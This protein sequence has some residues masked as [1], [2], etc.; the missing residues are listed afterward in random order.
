VAVYTRLDEADLKHMLS[1]YPVGELEEFEGVAAGS[2]NTMYRL[3]T[4]EGGYYLRVNEN[5][6]FGELVYEKNLL[7]H[8]GAKRG[9]L[10]GVK[11]PVL[12]ENVIG[13]TFFPLKGRWAC[14]FEELPGRE[15]AVFELLPSHTEQ[16][17]AFLAR[18]HRALRSFRGG[19]KN[20]FGAPVLGRW[21]E[22]MERRLPDEALKAR[23]RQSLVRAVSM[24]RPLPRGVVHG[25]LFMNNTKWRRGELDAVFDWE[26]AGRDHLALDLAICLHAWCWRREQRSFDP[27]LCRAL[28]AGYQSVRPLVPSERR[29]LFAEACL[30]ALRFTFSRIRDFQLTG[31]PPLDALRLELAAPDKAQKLLA[32][33]T[34]RDF[35]DYREYL[36]RL[37][38]VEALG[39]K[40]LAA[41]C[42]LAPSPADRRG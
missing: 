24:R 11:A 18:A 42:A 32:E 7:L 34:T 26:M 21:F 14:L 22:D 5:K 37:D 8:L 10:G 29:G 19:R 1:I 38:A 9:R 41:L 13:G 20:P 15:L 33:E 6:S 40:G 35:L 17:G 36:E 25:D 3:K 12:V 27:P 2:V 4:S 30:G 28:F 16:I 31:A 23:L 39:P